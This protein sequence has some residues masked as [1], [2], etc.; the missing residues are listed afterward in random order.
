MR[1]SVQVRVH[2]VVLNK[3][4][5]L[6]RSDLS[7]A[8]RSIVA[9]VGCLLPMLLVSSSFLRPLGAVSHC[10][11]CMSLLDSGL[12]SIAECMSDCFEHYLKTQGSRFA[13]GRRQ[14]VG[15]APALAAGC[16]AYRSS[17]C[18]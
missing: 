2:S 14:W 12:A 10:E 6:D 13:D 16:E 3:S 5:N 11:H 15:C 1:P 4:L 9:F 8:L 17:K 18:I 7:N